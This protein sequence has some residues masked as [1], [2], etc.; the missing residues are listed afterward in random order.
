M[1]E[2]KKENNEEKC[3]L[4]KKE[5]FFLP[6]STHEV[7]NPF[8]LPAKMDSKYLGYEEVNSCMPLKVIQ[9]KQ[10]ICNY[11][12]CFCNIYIVKVK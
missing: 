1:L 8:M 12:L 5:I 11:C 4:L 9:K 10:K 2:R 6:S 7:V 3:Q